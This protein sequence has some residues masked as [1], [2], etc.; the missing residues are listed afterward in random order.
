MDD[1]NKCVISSLCI[2]LRDVLILNNVQIGG[3]FFHVMNMSEGHE[4]EGKNQGWFVA[5]A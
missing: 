2:K 5:A 3:R 4:T 1:P